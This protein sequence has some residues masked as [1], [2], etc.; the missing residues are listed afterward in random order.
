MMIYSVHIYYSKHGTSGV[1][2]FE[3][4]YNQGYGEVTTA[5]KKPVPS[6]LPPKKAR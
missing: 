2:H 4:V 5:Q 6:A 1:E 3:M